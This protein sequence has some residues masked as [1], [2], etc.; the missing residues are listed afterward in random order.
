[1]A[2][3]LSIT[4]EPVI[5]FY[6]MCRFMLN[7]LSQ[8]LA[9]KK[10]CHQEYGDEIC[11]NLT[12]SQEDFVHQKTSKWILYQSVAWT[13]PS[14]FASLILGSWSDK[15][16][17]KVILILPSVGSVLLYVN[18]VLNVAFFSLHVNYLLIGVCVSGFFGGFATILLGVFSY[19]SDI[20]DKSQRTIRVAVL[21]SMIFMGGT[22]GSLIGGILLDHDGF[23]PAFGLCLGLTVLTILYI[24]FVLPESY[25]PQ[26]NQGKRPLV[27]MH[28]H[29]KAAFQVLTK[30]RAQH[31][32]L[33]LLV[34]LFGIAPFFVISMYVCFE[35]LI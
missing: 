14:I 3:R 29:L 15:V 2:V 1:M 16:G 7:P 31:K 8:Q 11:K 5:F 21:E 19:I 17:R 25:F 13:L 23:I 35:K 22:A 9:L 4:V 30:Q 34:I 33:N 10:I 6:M 12:K 28:N 26:G 27:A 24:S 18:Y 20:T 32:R